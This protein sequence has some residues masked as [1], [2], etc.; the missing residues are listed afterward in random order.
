MLHWDGR[1]EPAHVHHIPW[2][3]NPATGRSW[4]SCP[5]RGW[6]H[7]RVHLRTMGSLPILPPTVAD[8]GGR[9]AHARLGESSPAKA[10]GRRATP[11][12]TTTTENPA[13]VPPRIGWHP[14]R[15]TEQLRAAV[16]LDTIK[17]AQD[18]AQLWNELAAEAWEY[19][20]QRF[21]TEISQNRML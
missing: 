15:Q 7:R 18:R 21:P 20:L 11:A 2:G 3:V 16:S 12:S 10:Q 13:N 9:S 6:S 8:A 1:D 19:V 4:L 14:C 17:L 5:L